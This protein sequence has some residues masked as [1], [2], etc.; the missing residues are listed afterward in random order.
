LRKL[1]VDVEEDGGVVFDGVGVTE[2]AVRN[3]VNLS[4]VEVVGGSGGGVSVN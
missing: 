1:A 2:V 4:E 3:A